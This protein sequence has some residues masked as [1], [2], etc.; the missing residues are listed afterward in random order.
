ME[1]EEEE[2]TRKS[3]EGGSMRRWQGNRRGY[4]CWVK[5]QGWVKKN[6]SGTRVVEVGEVGCPFPSLPA[7]EGK[8]RLA[9]RNT[10]SVADT[11]LLQLVILLTAI[12]QGR[13][14]HPL[15]WGQH[16]VQRL[17][18]MELRFWTSNH[19]WTAHCCPWR[20][21]L[22]NFRLKTTLWNEHYLFHM[23]RNGDF[24]A[25]RGSLKLTL[26]QLASGQDACE[27]GYNLVLLLF[28]YT[29]FWR[30]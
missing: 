30:K 8:M 26:T 13:Q 15:C 17:S 1:V 10:S 2:R 28:Y 14:L 21:L 24:E 6:L 7:P 18:V 16:W 19:L 23:A 5:S 29:D 27:Q 11:V 12:L 20:T 25:L 22:P 9:I 4:E 3:R